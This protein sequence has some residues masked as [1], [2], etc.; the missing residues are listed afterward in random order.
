MMA[1]WQGSAI[2]K[3]KRQLKLMH[4]SLKLAVLLCPVTA[5]TQSNSTNSGSGSWY[6]WCMLWQQQLHWVEQTARHGMP[7]LPFE[8]CSLFASLNQKWVADIQP[9]MGTLVR[10]YLTKDGKTRLSHHINFFQP[11]RPPPTIHSRSSCRKT[12]KWQ[13]ISHLLAA[14][15]RSS[16]R[17]SHNI[18]TRTRTGTAE[19]RD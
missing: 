16:N 19:W 8:V 13:L 15:L 6:T 10:C 3:K 11:I 5:D 18:L 14:D 9:A 1:A 4:K 17:V 12:H 2:R 7:I